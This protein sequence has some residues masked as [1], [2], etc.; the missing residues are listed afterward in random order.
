M[1][2]HEN[3]LK[4]G[5]SAVVVVELELDKPFVV[6]QEMAAAVVVEQEL[7]EQIVV[8][9]E[10][11]QELVEPIVAEQKLVEFHL[12]KLIEFILL[13]DHFFEKFLLMLYD[14]ILRL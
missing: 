6:E 12:P 8:A 3:G 5:Y 9:V 13:L 1:K 4:G 7:V 10:V 14:R 2:G 11:E